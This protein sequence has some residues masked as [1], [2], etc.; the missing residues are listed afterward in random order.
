[1]KFVMRAKDQDH[2]RFRA[3]ALLAIGALD[4]NAGDWQVEIGPF[5]EPMTASQRGAIFGL[6]YVVVTDHTGFTKDEVHEFFL[7]EYFGWVEVDF[8]GKKV[9]KPART[10]TT[11]FDGKRH[12]LTKRETADYFTFIQNYCG[13][14]GIT[15]PDPDPL[16]KRRMYEEEAA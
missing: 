4:L 12:K 16:W 7:G 11:D 5:E 15:I 2:E 3:N 1:M 9:N 14:K 8:L 6:A 10:L 13:H